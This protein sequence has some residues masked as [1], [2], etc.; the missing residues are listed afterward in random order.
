M[1]ILWL[2]K[3]G[4]TGVILVM[5]FMLSV[6]HVTAQTFEEMPFLTESEPAQLKPRTNAVSNVAQP[7]ATSRTEKLP[8]VVAPETGGGFWHQRRLNEADARNDVALAQNQDHEPWESKPSPASS[9]ASSSP[10]GIRLVQG[11][12]PKVATSE[13][14][15]P[16]APGTYQG[17]GRI[18]PESV[19]PESTLSNE[20]GTLEPGTLPRRTLPPSVQG[21]STLPLPSNTLKPNSTSNSTER[22]PGTQLRPD[23]SAVSSMPMARPAATAT[24][25]ALSPNV[26][27]PNGYTDPNT[28]T[29]W[30]NGQ[31]GVSQYSDPEYQQYPPQNVSG[32]GMVAGGELYGNTS[33][34]NPY[35]QSYGVPMQG[36][37]YG[38]QMYGYP[39]VYG[40]YCGPGLGSMLLGNFACSNLWE[41]LSFGFGGTA[42]QSP[43]DQGE[44]GNF[45]FTESI[46]WVTPSTF[47]ISFQAGFRAVQANPAGYTANGSWNNGTRDQYFGT[48]GVFKR[49]IGCSPLN[50]GVAYDRM[51]DRYYGRYNLEQLRYE[52]SLNTMF[53]CD[54]G[55]RGAHGLRGDTVSMSRYNRD[56]NVY[57]VNYHTLFLRKY[58]AN[59]GEGS[60][61]GGASETGD[62]LVR[63]DFSIPLSDTWGLKNSLTYL[64]PRGGRQPGAFKKEAW[65]VSMELTW[66]PRGGILAGFCNP[67]RT[68]FDVAGN[69]T[70]LQGTTK[71]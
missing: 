28:E 27:S 47:P 36:G 40:G 46:N 18:L 2:K 57:A 66:Q 19:L 69:G 52:L 14:I 26:L 39:G 23:G 61:S 63:A 59:G 24:P 58:F 15:V 9:S 53:G 54:F 70:L 49:N 20:P 11:L 5:P 51:S 10:S 22:I 8:A 31:G 71:E 43:V 68:F 56:M 33:G 25:P 29:L 35:D 16:P 38:N 6:V 12:I 41:N 64:I 7:T 44:N 42:F 17:A 4:V 65:D 37:M 55:Y 67:F 21:L 30:E 60:L 1:K 32:M 3:L 34:V 50:F 13:K 48:M 62:A 45:G